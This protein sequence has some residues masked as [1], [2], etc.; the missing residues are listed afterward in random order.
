M[1]N[2]SLIILLVLVSGCNQIYYATGINCPQEYTKDMSY[3]AEVGI[4]NDMQAY[5]ALIKYVRSEAAI[6]RYGQEVLSWDLNQTNVVFRNIKEN[7]GK[8][9]SAWTLNIVAI[10]REGN[11]YNKLRCL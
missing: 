1:K 4:T 9:I 8:E 5:D 10:D 7:T 3:K 2:Y 6:N 11:V